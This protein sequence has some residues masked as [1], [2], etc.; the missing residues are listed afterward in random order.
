M[1]QLPW[2][3]ARASGI[4]AWALVSAS[5]L[6]G[7][8][9]SGRPF[10]RKPH[11]AW[12][13]DLHRYLGGLA[14]VFTGLHIA[15]VIADSYVHFTLAAVLVPFVATWRP[16]AVAWGIVGLYLLLAIELTSLAR[17]RLSKRA[18]RAVHFASFPLFVVATVHGLTAGSD[19]TSQLALLVAGAVT[20]LVA[21]LTV[22]RIR[23]AKRSARRPAAAAQPAR[24]RPERARVPVHL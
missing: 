14:T 22:V 5:V 15:A 16:L 19:T 4:V 3:V 8:T 10:G 21:A 23:D 12:L 18:W 9:L 2:F 11:P 17:R 13:L 1:S 6:W 7:L 24:P 20:A